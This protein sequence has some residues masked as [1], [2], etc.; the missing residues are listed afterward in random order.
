MKQFV[1]QLLQ[2]YADLVI[3]LS[4]IKKMV[5]I[6]F[7]IVYSL[8]YC[9]I[10]NCRKCVFQRKI[11]LIT[12]A[13]YF[14][15]KE[16]TSFGKEAVLTAWDRYEKDTFTPSVIIGANCH[17]GDYLHL[18]CISKIS[19]GNGVLT[20]RWVTITD[21][22]HGRTEEITST[23]EPSKRKLYSKGPVIIDDNVW[24]GDKVTILP[25]TLIGKGCII[26]A[27]SVVT[28]NIPAYSLACGNPAR[29]IKTLSSSH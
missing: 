25:N 6:I 7:Q 4:P 15:I 3:L 5:N 11:N 20:G 17:F 27:N 26:G 13:K 9:A 1:K 18:T 10:F 14:K 28:N 24:I 2:Y 19:I 29:V 8:E 12:G 21:N 23:T 16:G 22:S